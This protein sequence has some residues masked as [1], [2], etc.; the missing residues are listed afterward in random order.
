[1]EDF[2]EYQNEFYHVIFYMFWAGIY[3]SPKRISEHGYLH[4]MYGYII[5]LILLVIEKHS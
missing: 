2:P 4:N 1:M 3:H 5:I